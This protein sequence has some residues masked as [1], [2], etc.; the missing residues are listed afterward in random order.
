VPGA[1]N[2]VPEATN[3]IGDFRLMPDSGPCLELGHGDFKGHERAGQIFELLRAAGAPGQNGTHRPNGLSE[4]TSVRQIAVVVAVGLLDRLLKQE[5]Q[6]VDIDP[7]AMLLE[8]LME[9]PEEEPAQRKP[10]SGK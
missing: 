2:H 10:E 5:R 9:L 7:W 4:A 8:Q 1:V 3:P 6:F